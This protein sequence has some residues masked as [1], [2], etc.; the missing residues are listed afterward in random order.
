MFS[1]LAQFLKAY[2]ECQQLFKKE[3]KDLE[4]TND[5]EAKDGSNVV[6]I[7][8]DNVCKIVLYSA[9]HFGGYS[10]SFTETTSRIQPLERSLRTIG[11]CC[12]RIVR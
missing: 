4:A 7:D 8:D 1:I 5:V 2:T 9:Q 11:S 10:Q 6:S 3:L 12:W